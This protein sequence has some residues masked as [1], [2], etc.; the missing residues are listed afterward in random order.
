M[1]KAVTYQ[2]LSSDLEN[3]TK[4]YMIQFRNKIKYFEAFLKENKPKLMSAHLQHLFNEDH[5]Q[6]SQMKNKKKVS[7]TSLTSYNQ[8]THFCM[9][10]QTKSVSKGDRKKKL[11]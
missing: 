7:N 11:K 6:F 8:I 10:Q 9:I 1:L 2:P 5:I 4:Q 3:N